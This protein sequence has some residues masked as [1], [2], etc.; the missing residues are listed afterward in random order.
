MLNN[1]ITPINRSNLAFILSMSTTEP[2]TFK[3]AMSGPN[4][5][6]WYKAC[7]DEVNELERQNTYDIID[8][9]PNIKPLSGRWVFKEKPIN[10]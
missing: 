9:P 6:Q 4:S 3:Q 5:D 1:I 7:L 2:N 8:I 10:K